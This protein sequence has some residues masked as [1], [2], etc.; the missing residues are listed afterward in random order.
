MGT[1]SEKD[2]IRPEDERWGSAVRLRLALTH[3]AS[4]LELIEQVLTEAQRASAESGLSAH[5][6]FGEAESHADDVAD[7]RISQ[8]ERAAVDMDGIAPAEQVQGAL[9]AVGF[10][11]VAFSIMLVVVRGWVVEVSPWQLVLLAAGKVAFTAAVVAVM[12][13]RAGPLRRS[14]SLVA[15]TVA[16]LGAGTALAMPLAE[17]P[18]LGE[19][20]S[21]VPLVVYLALFIV[22]WNMPRPVRR[23]AFP[24]NL[25]N[26]EWFA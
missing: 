2:W 9:L 25:S 10:A 26:E 22:A 24:R 5:E 14:W 7:E 16:A 3:P 1:F 8:E 4:T 15:V 23:A 18:P 11:G 6:L 21:L 19:L 20:S 17:R 12:S 13:R